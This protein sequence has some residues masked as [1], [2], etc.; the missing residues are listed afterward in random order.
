[1]L[2]KFRLT[3]SS[4]M[5][6]A[7]LTFPTLAMGLLQARH[8]FVLA[9]VSV[10]QRDYAVATGAGQEKIAR[11]KFAMDAVAT[12]VVLAPCFSQ[13]LHEQLLPILAN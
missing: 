1:M 6:I 9:M 7:H 12:E 5:I 4:M 11:C 3:V 10:N 8:M 2:F 13:T